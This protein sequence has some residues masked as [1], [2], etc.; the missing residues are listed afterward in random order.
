MIGF[1]DLLLLYKI[2]VLISNSLLFKYLKYR[3]I[4]LTLDFQFCKENSK[5]NK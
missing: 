2:N 3:Q 1:K 4:S 5:L